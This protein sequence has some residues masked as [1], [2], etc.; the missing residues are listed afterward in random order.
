MYDSDL[1]TTDRPV[2][3]GVA[4]EPAETDDLTSGEETDELAEPAEEELDT[5]AA[6]LD[7]VEAA[8]KAL[9]AD[10]MDDA[11]R[12]AGSLADGGFAEVD[13]SAVES[14]PRED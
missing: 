9:D 7:T 8:M 12:L 10:A 14:A 13:A 1:P 6:D 4:A 11:E 3:E 2:S 5:I